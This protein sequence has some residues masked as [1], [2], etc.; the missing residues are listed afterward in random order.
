MAR[1]HQLARD[2][3]TVQDARADESSGS[4]YG[5][6]PRSA[7]GR[8][9][10]DEG[11]QCVGRQPLGQDVGI[12]RTRRAGTLLL[13]RHR[14]FFPCGDLGGRGASP[15][16]PAGDAV[17]E[18]VPLVHRVALV[19]EVALAEE[20]RVAVAARLRAL[21]A[22]RERAARGE[23]RVEDGAPDRRH[24][25][26]PHLGLDRVLHLR[27]PEVAEVGYAVE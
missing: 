15:Q 27:Q 22:R 24:E 5:G 25:E 3:V 13:P 16:Q 11:G 10:T 21:T 8:W 6:G 1:G 7:G 17:G 18:E 26:V 9:G 14:L 23:A 2:V 20:R 4:W 12:D 19:E